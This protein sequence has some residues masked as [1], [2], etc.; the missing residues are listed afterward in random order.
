M[1]K[2]K[3][4]LEH[5]EFFEDEILIRNSS[6]AYLDQEYYEFKEGVLSGKI[7]ELDCKNPQWLDLYY[8]IKKEYNKNLIKEISS[9]AA[10]NESTSNHSD[11][12]K[13]DEFRDLDPDLD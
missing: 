11:L 1:R 9:S 7:T 4:P 8:E 2:V 3:Q 12:F 6:D 10:N 13:H 5:N